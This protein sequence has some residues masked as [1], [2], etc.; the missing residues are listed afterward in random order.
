MVRLQAE[1]GLVGAVEHGAR[2]CQLVREVL[3]DGLC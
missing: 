1:V 2:A 3:H